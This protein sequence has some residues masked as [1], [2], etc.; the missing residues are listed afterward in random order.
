[1]FPKP[2]RFSFLLMSF[3]Q[4]MLALTILHMEE[5]KIL[6][7]RYFLYFITLI[8]MVNLFKLS[9]YITIKPF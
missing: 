2:L 3:R 4:L 5:E 9:I 7:R 6:H 8:M 1:M